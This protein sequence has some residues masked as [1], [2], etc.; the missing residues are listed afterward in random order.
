MRRRPVISWP[1]RRPH[2]AWPACRRG[3]PTRSLEA[4]ACAGAFCLHLEPLCSSS[5]L[6]ANAPLQLC[7]CPC[8][9]TACSSDSGHALAAHKVA[10]QTHTVHADLHQYRDD[11]S[12]RPRGRSPGATSRAPNCKQTC[13]AAASFWLVYRRQRQGWLRLQQS[14]V[15]YTKSTE[16]ARSASTAEVEVPAPQRQQGVYKGGQRQR[17]EDTRR[18]RWQQQE[19]HRTP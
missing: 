8:A 12:P 17:V 11:C 18:A 15:K 6:V 4:C 13:I 10:S 16:S 5:E 14:M 2:E 9:G 7:G 1:A 3:P 19:E